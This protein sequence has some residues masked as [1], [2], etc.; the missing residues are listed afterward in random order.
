MRTLPVCSVKE[1]RG[2]FVGIPRVFLFPR[3]KKKRRKKGVPYDPGA[4]HFTHVTLLRHVRMRPHIRGIHKEIML[5]F[6]GNNNFFF[7]FQ[8]YVVINRLRRVG[9]SRCSYQ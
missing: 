4:C 5:T 9:T 8:H 3:G 7:H 2:P 6:S 1:T